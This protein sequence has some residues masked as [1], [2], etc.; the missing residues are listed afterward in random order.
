MH[1]NLFKLMTSILILYS[2]YSHNYSSLLM[3]RPRIPQ[4]MVG[5]AGDPWTPSSRLHEEVTLDPSTYAHHFPAMSGKHQD[6]LE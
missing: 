6:L 1:S 5:K 4:C 2:R 3:G